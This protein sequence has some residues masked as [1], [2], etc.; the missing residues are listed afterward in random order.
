MSHTVSTLL[1]RNLNDVFGEIDPVRRRAAI[2]EIFHEDA[3]FHE[4]NGIYRGRNEI[5]RIAGVIKATHPDFQYQLVARLR[6][7]ATAGGSVGWRV[8]RASRRLSPEPI[9]SLPTTA[10][11]PPSISFSMAR[12]MPRGRMAL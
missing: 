5:N 6:S 4:P 12:A 9:S 10:R 1:L 2:D 7:W 8:A 3:V 11:L